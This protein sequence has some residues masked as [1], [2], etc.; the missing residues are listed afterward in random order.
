MTPALE[1]F[2][3]DAERLVRGHP[4]LLADEVRFYAVLFER[5]RF[6]ILREMFPSVR[7]LALATDEALWP[8][9]VREYSADHPPCDRDP[10]RFGASFPAWLGRRARTVGDAPELLEELADYH[11]ACHQVAVAS[12]LPGDGFE[13]RLLVRAYRWNVPE[14]VAALAGADVP[15]RPPRRDTL[16]V[17]YRDERSRA[18]R[19]FFP[20]PLGLVALA[21]RQGTCVPA[22]LQA[23]DAAIDAA[24]A[25]LIEAG[26]LRP[27]AEPGP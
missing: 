3:A 21:R 6:K 16:V 14:L 25:G 19:C 4:V 22:A 5:N 13:R 23:S 24:E 27:R 9:L 26:V 10:N 15:P 2:F 17:V 8:T 12:D 20:T 11:L 1:S 18:A 7:R